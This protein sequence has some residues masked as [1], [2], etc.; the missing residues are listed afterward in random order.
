MNTKLHN[1]IVPGP[2]RF[3]WAIALLLIGSL[4]LAA[5]GQSLQAAATATPAIPATVPGTPEPSTTGLP[6]TDGEEAGQR[7]AQELATTLGVPVLD[8]SIDN[9]ESVQW[10]DTCLGINVRGIMCAQHVVP[11]HKVVLSVHDRSYTYH[12][13]EDGSSLAAV[14]DLTVTWGSGDK[15][16]TTD[17][18][19]DQGITY[20]PCGGTMATAA[21]SNDSQRLDLSGFAT[22]FAPFNGDTLAGQVMLFGTGELEVTPEEGRML[23]EWGRATVEEA[24]ALQGTP[25]YGLVLQWHR[26]GGV[27]GFCDDLAVYISGKAV[28]T[29][30]KGGRQTDVGQ[31]FLDA[32]QLT[33]LYGWVDNLASFEMEQVTPSAGAPDALTIGIVF[34]GDGTTE[35]TDSEKQAMDTFASQVFG[36]ISNP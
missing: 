35:A 11:G 26:E 3:A 13:N 24:T 20:G 27:A 4:L 23:G 31:L 12:T 6:T 17:L 2:G 14:P 36:E 15:C 28:A 29:S 7:A 18:N 34:A 19:Y 10:P 22:R 8:I 21:F 9:I 32:A 30:C 33:T 5:C 25:P 16:Q 1:R